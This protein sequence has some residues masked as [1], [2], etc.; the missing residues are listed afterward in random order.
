MTIEGDLSGG[1]SFYSVECNTCFN[2]FSEKEPVALARP[3][4]ELNHRRAY[5][6]AR[7]HESESDQDHHLVIKQWPR[8]QEKVVYDIK[9]PSS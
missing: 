2:P 7:L 9:R 1:F 6:L 3:G 4:D 5:N 8:P